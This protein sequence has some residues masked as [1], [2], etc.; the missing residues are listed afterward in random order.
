MILADKAVT[1]IKRMGK[2]T[3][4]TVIHLICIM[5]GVYLTFNNYSQC[6]TPT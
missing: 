1:Y 3:R 5:K 2:E 6:T 4:K